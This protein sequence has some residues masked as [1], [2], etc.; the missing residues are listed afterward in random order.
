MVFVPVQ[1]G[2]MSA[3]EVFWP[4]CAGAANAWDL[5]PYSKGT[6][7]VREAFRSR[8]TCEGAAS[9]WNVFP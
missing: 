4:T 2:A 1:Q 5:V 6:S 8:S 9:V 3:R 7:N